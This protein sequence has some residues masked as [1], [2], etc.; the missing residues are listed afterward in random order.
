MCGN[1]GRHI[2][3]N[4][5]CMNFKLFGE[6]LQHTHTHWC[7]IGY[8]AIGRRHLDKILCHLELSG[9]ESRKNINIAQDIAIERNCH[10]NAS[11]S[12]YPLPDC[13]RKAI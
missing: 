2:A 5:N 13:R 4:T 6:E 10:S 8:Q 7:H 12:I 3:I 1:S 9:C 11:H